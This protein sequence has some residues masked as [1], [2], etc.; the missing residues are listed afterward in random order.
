MKQSFSP[1]LQYRY[2]KS[3]DAI[4]HSD[5]VLLQFT[6]GSYT[7]TQVA[8]MIVALNKIAYELGQKHEEELS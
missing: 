7:R 4:A 2:S 6:S 5:R 8:E 3:T 1:L